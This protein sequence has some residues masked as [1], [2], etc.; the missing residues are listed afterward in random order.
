MAS[1]A[2]DL[3]I[4]SFL[5]SEWAAGSGEL[6][7]ENSQSRPA[8]SLGHPAVADHSLMA[9]GASTWTTRI[10]RRMPR[11]E[12]FEHPSFD[13]GGFKLGWFGWLSQ[14]QDRGTTRSPGPSTKVSVAE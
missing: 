3:G 11:P 14:K 13:G 1:A 9:A 4:V 12:C 5:L 6:I 8:A 10:R 7:P 2:E